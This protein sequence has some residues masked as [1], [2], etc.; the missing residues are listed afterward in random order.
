MAAAPEMPGRAGQV[1]RELILNRLAQ[2]V[3]VR[4]ATLWDRLQ[5]L[6]RLRRPLTPSASA[7]AAPAEPQQGQADRAERELLEVLLAEPQLMTRVRG[8]VA[9][10]QVRHPGL[11]R[12]L[13]EMYALH[14][15]GQPAGVDPLRSALEDK[16][17]LR[18]YLLVLQ[19]AGLAKGRCAERLDDLLR[20]F[21]QR[22]LA[23]QVDELQGRLRQIPD[24]GPVPVELLRQLQS[25]R[26]DAPVG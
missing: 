15:A 10:D 19:G 3:G 6:R 8:Q 18:E 17:R 25:K 26:L 16:P 21:R 11:R 24:D 5:E 2:R 20:E 13:N 7:P 4:E 9:V 23:T 12:V 22:Q 14:E 1:K